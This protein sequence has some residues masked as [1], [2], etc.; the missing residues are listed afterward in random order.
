MQI[1]AMAESGVNPIISIHDHGAAVTLTACL[2][3]WKKQEESINL[4][5]LPIG[6]PTLSDKENHQQ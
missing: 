5:K 4:S 1:R 2:N 3:C 6:D